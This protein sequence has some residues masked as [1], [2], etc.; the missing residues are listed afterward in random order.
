[1]A[2]GAIGNPW[3]FQQVR[4]LAAGRPYR[5]PGLHQQRAVIAEHFRLAEETYGPKIACARMRKFGIKYAR[6]CI[7]ATSKCGPRLPSL[8]HGRLGRR[9]WDGWYIED[10]P[11]RQPAEL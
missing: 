10:L 7:P 2:R 8:E 11:G 4:E 6:G 1:V 3:I 5:L 9:C